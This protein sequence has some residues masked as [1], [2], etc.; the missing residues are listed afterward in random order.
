MAAR[1]GD[2][3]KFPNGD[4]AGEVERRRS[5]P[6]PLRGHPHPFLGLSPKSFRGCHF[7]LQKIFLENVITPK[8]D[9]VS[10]YMNESE[11]NRRTWSTIRCS[12]DTIFC[13]TGRPA[14]G[15]CRR[16][17]DSVRR[18]QKG[19][20]PIGLMPLSNAAMARR[21]VS[22]GSSSPRSCQPCNAGWSRCQR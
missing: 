9:H 16:G 8:V 22:G 1:P 10:F 21:M 7:R 3:S 19:Y 18:H 5:G 2:L 11:R 6:Y 14:S 20:S 4:W 13:R 15:A 17:A 12:R